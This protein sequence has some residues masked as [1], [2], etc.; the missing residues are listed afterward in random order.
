MRG[1]NK[2][3]ERVFLTGTRVKSRVHLEDCTVPEI[4]KM[5]RGE[6][7]WA[8]SWAGETVLEMQEK[9]ATRLFLRFLRWS[10]S[11]LARF[12]YLFITFSMVSCRVV[13]RSCSEDT[14]KYDP[15]GFRIF[16]I[17]VKEWVYWYAKPSNPPP[18]PDL[19]TSLQYGVEFAEIFSILFLPL[20]KVRHDQLWDHGVTA[21]ANPGDRCAMEMW[22]DKWGG[23]QFPFRE[24]RKSA[25]CPS[26]ITLK[27]PPSIPLSIPTSIPTLILL[28]LSLS[29]SFPLSLLLSIPC[30]ISILINT[31]VIASKL[32]VLWGYVSTASSIQNIGPEREMINSSL[33]I[34]GL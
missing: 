2:C 1:T 17:L 21:V 12:P 11:S 3:E 34:R 28:P 19:H 6:S 10:C 27:I 13:N 24:G 23:K 25:L 22:T 33:Q 31:S 5:W 4:E 18:G 30:S 8:S 9:W 15:M 14:C 16:T 7:I 29:C 26:Y 32:K 20:T